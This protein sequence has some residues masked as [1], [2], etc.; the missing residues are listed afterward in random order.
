M[1]VFSK[2][3]FAFSIN[4]DGK[5]IIWTYIHESRFTEL[6]SFC[7]KSFL[8]PLG[9]KYSLIAA[10]MSEGKIFDRSG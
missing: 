4:D 10:P 6:K 8:A 1:D 7:F 9:Q 2:N 5:L 3:G